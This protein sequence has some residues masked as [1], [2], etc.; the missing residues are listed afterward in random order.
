VVSDPLLPGFIIG[1]APRSGTSALAHLLDR[2]PDIAMAKPFVPEPKVFLA[3]GSPRERYR[4]LY[5]HAG[6]ER[7]RGEKTTNYFESAAAA[8][9]IRATL[10]GVRMVFILR[11]PVARAYSNWLWSRKNGHEHLPFAE[12]VETED[13]R[14]DPLAATHPHARP[15]AYLARGRY[16]DLARP[17]LDSFAPDQV[18]FVLY[19]AMVGPAGADV[20]REVQDYVGVEP[21]DLGS[22]PTGLPNETQETGPGLDP[23]LRSR[24]RDGFRD[25]VRA[26]A[27]MSGVDVAPWE[28]A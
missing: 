24:L 9:A 28:Y 16:A 27:D 12:A 2:H 1:G 4:E 21:R 22:L 19:E 14:E 5:S 7:V 17:W 26:F 8:T 10:P 23:T 20:L 18:R 13:T 6:D 11:E 15:F 3:P 25:Q